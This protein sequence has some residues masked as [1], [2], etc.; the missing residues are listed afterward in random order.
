M[1]NST[2]IPV[3]TLIANATAAVTECVFTN[4]AATTL[5]APVAAAGGSVDRC[6]LVVR[7][8]NTAGTETLTVTVNG[9]TS[10]PSHYG[11][12]AAVTAAQLTAT[13]G[14]ITLGPFDQTRYDNSGSLSVTFTP[15]AAL[16]FR[17]SVYLL[18]Q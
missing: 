14:M 18:P 16:A 1:I 5:L 6:I 17:A 2:N 13:S 9:N 15:G 3:A 4:G 10:L 12:V 8:A 11:T 7:H